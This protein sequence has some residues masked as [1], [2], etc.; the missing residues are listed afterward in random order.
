M[1]K[2]PH[3]RTSE[4]PEKILTSMILSD[5]GCSRKHLMRIHRTSPRGYIE[6]NAAGI[7]LYQ[8]VIHFPVDAE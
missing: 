3:F 2:S 1:R 8:V 7:G 6:D 5:H 4:K